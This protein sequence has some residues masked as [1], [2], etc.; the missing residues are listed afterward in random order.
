MDPNS[1]YDSFKLR[2]KDPSFKN[3]KR[4]YEMN[5]GN[6]E[7][8]GTPAQNIRMNNDLK[9]GHLYFNEYGEKMLI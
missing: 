6:E 2:G 3:R 5:Y 9:Q 1:V 4:I 8:R 7:Y